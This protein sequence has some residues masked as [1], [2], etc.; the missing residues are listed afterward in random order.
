VVC[1][2]PTNEFVGMGVQLIEIR[3]GSARAYQS[4]IA[5]VADEQKIPRFDQVFFIVIRFS[6]EVSDVIEIYRERPNGAY[7]KDRKAIFRLRRL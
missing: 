2:L 6:V 7:A 4:R 5:V 1:N 3:N